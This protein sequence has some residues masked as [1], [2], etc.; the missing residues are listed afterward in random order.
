LTS[1]NT[2]LHARKPC[3]Q[4][5]RCFADLAGSKIDQT[6]GSRRPYTFTRSEEPGT[7]TRAATNSAMRMIYYWRHYCTGQESEEKLTVWRYSKEI[8]TSG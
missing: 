6:D 7:A 4:L 1:A 2:N 5:A 8:E 3:Y